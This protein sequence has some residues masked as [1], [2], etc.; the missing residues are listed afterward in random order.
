MMGVFSTVFFKDESKRLKNIGQNTNC[1]KELGLQEYAA[2]KPKGKGSGNS[3]F[4]GQKAADLL[5]R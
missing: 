2:K 1:L 5:E 3:C 4:S